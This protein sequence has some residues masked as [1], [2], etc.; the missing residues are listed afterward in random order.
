MRSVKKKTEEI[1]HNIV[2]E[3]LALSFICET[4]IDTEDGVTKVKL[5]TESY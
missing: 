2:E 4:W 5:K 3:E 1:I